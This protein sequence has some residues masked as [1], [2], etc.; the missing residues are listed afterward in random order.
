MN[1]SKA[2]TIVLL[3]IVGSTF[4]AAMTLY[5]FPNLNHLVDVNWLRDRIEARAS[6]ESVD[7]ADGVDR[8][9]ATA[10]MNRYVC[11]ACGGCERVDEARRVRSK[12]VAVARADRG[13]HCVGLVEVDQRTG[14]VESRLCQASG[15][16]CR[17]FPDAAS[18]D[19]FQEF[20][21]D[22]AAYWPVPRGFSSIR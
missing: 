4:G 14:A 2:A 18:F 11:V 10:I 17:V 7:I 5:V 8:D 3:A 9:E 19:S 12:W 22:V 21:N 20:W 16:A 1:R 6:L 13:G 15:G